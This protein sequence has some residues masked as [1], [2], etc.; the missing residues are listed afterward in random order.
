MYLRTLIFK[1]FLLIFFLSSLWSC[2]PGGSKELDPVFGGDTIGDSAFTSTPSAL[3]F[4]NVAVASTSNRTITIKN[5]SKSNIFIS[6][7]LSN[8]ASYQ[9]I[10][11]TCPE[12]PS[13]IAPDETCDITVQFSPNTGGVVGAAVG[14]RY[15]ISAATSSQYITNFG[16]SGR[17][18]SPLV[19]NGLSSLGPQTHKSMTL[20]WLPNSD[21]TSFIIFRMIGGMMV[22]EKTVVNG[23]GTV[24][25]EEVTGLMPS[26]SY[27]WR[28][29]A[30]DVFGTS[31][32]NTVDLSALTDVNQL[33]LL[34]DPGPQTLYQGVT[35]SLDLE[36]SNTN[37]DID[38]DGDP[39]TYSCYY[40][41]TVDGVVASVT[42]CPTLVNENT[43]AATF[44]TAT[45]EFNWTP[46]YTI[47]PGTQYEVRVTG[48]DPFGALSSRVIVLT[49][50][51]GVP[52][53]EWTPAGHF[54]FPTQFITTSSPLSADFS[55]ARTGND[56][57]VATYSCN[58]DRVI[59]SAMVGSTTCT[60]LPGVASF[61]TTTGQLNWTPNSSAWGPY[62][63][64]VT[65]TN[66]AGSDTE[67]IKVNVRSE[68]D[69][70]NLVAYWD[71]SFADGEKF[72]L[73]SP[74]LTQWKDL[75]TAATTYDGVLTNFD[76]LISSGWSNAT[77]PS[78]ALDGVDDRVSFSNLLTPLTNFSIDTWIKPNT[79]ISGIIL[80]NYDGAGL[81][82]TLKQ[83]AV[84]SGKFVL[85]AGERTF[86]EEILADNPLGYWRFNEV[87]GN[88]AYDISGNNHHG[89]YTASVTKSQGGGIADGDT[90]IGVNG[91]NGSMNAPVAIGA[92]VT[93]E[94]WAQ[95]TSVATTPMLWR[96]GPNGVGPDLFFMNNRISLN[97]W[98]SDTNFFCTMPVAAT[99]GN[100]H[101]Y[102]VTIDQI[103]NTAQ[104]YF[105][106]VLCGSAAYRNPSA[107]SI[108]FSSGLGS[109]EWNGRIDE[110]AVYSTIL[111]PARIQAHYNARLR[112]TCRSSMAAT[113]NQWMHIFAGYTN[114]TRTLNMW[115]N[116]RNQ[117]TNVHHTNLQGS[118]Q[119]LQL[120]QSV[121]GMA[122]WDGSVGELRAYS[123]AVTGPATTN[124]SIMQPKYD[125]HIPVQD[126]RLWLRADSL[127]YM[128]DGAYISIW[129]DQSG[130]NNHAV[131]ATAADQPVFTATGLNGQPSVSFAGD[132]LRTSAANI[133]G[134]FSVFIVFQDTTIG[135][136]ERI[137]D[138][139]YIG[140]FWIGRDGS[141]ANSMKS[142]IL[143][144]ASPYGIANTYT[145]NTPH[146]LTSIRSGTNHTLMSN[147]ASPVSQVVSSAATTSTVYGVGCLHD[148]SGGNRFNGGHISEIIVY[149]TVLSSA[150]QTRV[151]RYLGDKYSI[152]VP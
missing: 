105:D 100:F 137:F 77:T 107:A 95:T 67:F 25:S 55:N 72:G 53:L 54:T 102:V 138:K 49:V 144:S 34:V 98:D 10:S 91:A 20:N 73:N 45:G 43:T 88:I 119:N 143:Q 93:I 79:D 78:L 80:S 52:I 71:A 118:A 126:M 128:G 85:V 12:S 148:G 22:F 132:C 64:Q 129:K 147:G 75:T 17:G 84:E 59:D 39:L 29:R 125:Q 15:G 131:Q 66:A 139:D 136:H 96:T 120:G 37:D 89:T 83:S 113:P 26:T 11:E 99:D 3:D 65:A 122:S 109:Y 16:V 38:V 150:D 86:E 82:L 23:T 7:I 108:T 81:G 76:A 24:D 134:N 110:A 61:N 74:L 97:T 51:T 27:T 87:T 63:L 35:W 133:L 41:L 19:F 127:K 14:V 48:T 94:V 47:V 58:F 112:A 60:S 123:S 13:V 33:P 121:N 117:C 31:D 115:V 151:H 46:P 149:N 130:Q 104:L 135:D 146:I 18:V 4:G 44:N 145:D 101:Q 152:T 124:Y 2:T 6:T 36:D 140:G 111:S 103:G 8:S 114:G 68:F 70:T 42:A 9:V 142:G 57:G 106:G 30:V 90:A 141:N 5:A 69:S 32:S 62:E 92:T 50:N 28:V 1:I 116:G 56:S 40:D 21:A